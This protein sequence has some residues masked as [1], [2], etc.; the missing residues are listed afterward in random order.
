MDCVFSHAKVR[1]YLSLT[2]LLHPLWMFEQVLFHHLDYI[3]GLKDDHTQQEIAEKM[4]WTRSTVA[5]YGSLLN[6][7]VTEVLKIAKSHQT[8]RVTGTVPTETFTERWFRDSDLYDLARD[9]TTEYAKPDEGPLPGQQFLGFH[10]DSIPKVNPRAIIKRYVGVSDW[11]S[12]R[13]SP[14]A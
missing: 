1:R 7:L 9:G 10:P 2:I 12:W 13:F 3:E 14:A 5:N 4:G 8:G 6:N 11:D